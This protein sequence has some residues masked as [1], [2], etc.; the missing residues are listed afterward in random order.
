VAYHR[1]YPGADDQWEAVDDIVDEPSG[2]GIEVEL[3][4]V[5]AYTSVLVSASVTVTSPVREELDDAITTAFS[6]ST[7][8]S[9]ASGDLVAVE[10]VGYSATDLPDVDGRIVFTPGAVRA[11]DEP[12]ARAAVFESPTEGELQEMIVPPIWG[13]P[14]VDGVD[15]LPDLPVAKIHQTDGDWL[16]DRLSG[17]DVEVAVETQARTEQR[18]LPCPVARIEGTESDRYSVVGNRIDS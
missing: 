8:P 15:E 5:E 10:L 6:A 1:R 7:P 14:S 3:Q 9:G 16:A 2:E 4:T 13:S 11:I 17:D 18:E 12:G